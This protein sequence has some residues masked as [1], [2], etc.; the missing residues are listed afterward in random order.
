MAMELYDFVGEMNL[1]ESAGLEVEVAFAAYHD[2]L[3]WPALPNLSGAIANY[4]YVDMKASPFVMKTGKMFHKFEGSLEKNAFQSTLVGPE[5]ALTWLNTLTVAKSAV[6]KH[7]IGWLR[8]N[9]NRPLVVAFRFLGETQ[10]TVMGY[11]KLWA[12]ITGATLD[13]AAEV[14]GEKSSSFSVK[15]IFYPPL[16]IDAIPFT[17]AIGALAEVASLLLTAAVT[18]AGNV[19]VTLNGVAVLVAVALSDTAAQVATKIRATAFAGW[20]TGGTAETV[21][22]TSTTTGAKTDAVYSAGTTGA[23][24]TMSTTVQ[25]S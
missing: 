2:V 19:T 9:R 4:E 12:Q 14:S 5:Q 15:S 8:A 24:G 10:Y 21:T 23:A 1:E 16:Y 25:G 17:A 13:V 22:F 6:N 20:T 7:V 3:T 18:T 11:D